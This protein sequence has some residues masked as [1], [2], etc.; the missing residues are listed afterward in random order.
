MQQEMRRRFYGR[1]SAISHQLSA[2]SYQ[3]SVLSL[4]DLE[5]RLVGWALS[6]EVAFEVEGVELE[7]LLHDG[8]RTLG[9]LFEGAEEDCLRLVQEEQAVGELL[10]KSHVMSHDNTGQL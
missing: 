5:A 4:T 2:I 9:H 7:E 1:I 10:G 3:L 6:A 8:L